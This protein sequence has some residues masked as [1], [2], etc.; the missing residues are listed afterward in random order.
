MNGKGY[1]KK[2]E[3]F[4]LIDKFE[5]I[6][7]TPGFLV[8]YSEKELNLTPKDTEHIRPFNTS[9]FTLGK[10]EGIHDIIKK[11]NIKGLDLILYSN[12]TISD[13]EG[14]K[15]DFFIRYKLT[16]D[17]GIKEYDEPICSIGTDS[18]WNE[19]KDFFNRG[20]DLAIEGL[21]HRTLN[22]PVI[23]GEKNIIL[24]ESMITYLNEEIF[25]GLSEKT[26]YKL[27]P[28]FESSIYKLE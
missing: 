12:N 8:N 18:S 10:V 26:K 23:N 27:P 11:E 20:F 3:L 25:N 24:P 15:K 14:Y 1:E 21:L 7:Q 19:K 9:Y 13:N 5:S 16:T 4:R 22:L 6:A 28:I 2:R 17:K